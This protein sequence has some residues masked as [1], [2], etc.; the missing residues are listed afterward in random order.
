MQ[1]FLANLTLQAESYHFLVDQR[2]LTHTEI[3][4]TM[5]LSRV[6]PRMLKG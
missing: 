6:D 5:R 4:I 3:S 2:K 1:L